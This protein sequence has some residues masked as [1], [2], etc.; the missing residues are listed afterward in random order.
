[1]SG[2]SD[3]SPSGFTRRQFGAMVV[4]GAAV[5]AVG[6]AVV[7]TTSGV[8]PSAPGAARTSFGSVA[9]ERAKRV[10]RFGSGTFAVVSDPGGHGHGSPYAPAD[11]SREPV[12]LTWADVVVL[13]LAVKNAGP[14]P[15]HLSPGQL[16]LRI[17][18]AGTTVTPRNFG[19][20]RLEIPPGGS[21]STWISYLAPAAG[22]SGFLAEFTDPALDGALTLTLPA[23]LAQAEQRNDAEPW[24]A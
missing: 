20:A 24:A 10:T 17:V 19:A 4:G 5:V 16:R 2:F 11:P 18:G 22:A 13:W 3:P 7:A 23:T 9:I 8:L 14:A 12:N 21:A 1:M 15:V 6:S